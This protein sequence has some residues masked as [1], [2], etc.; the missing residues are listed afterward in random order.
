[1]TWAADGSVILGKTRPVPWTVWRPPRPNGNSAKNGT[2][3]KGPAQSEPR[4]EGERRGRRRI[5]IER[6]KKTNQ[7]LYEEKKRKKRTL[8]HG[9]T[10]K[11]MFKKLEFMMFT[12]E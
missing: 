7:A 5:A 6:R 4:G 12:R 8:R 11:A 3:K 9:L 1:L 10:I 2:I